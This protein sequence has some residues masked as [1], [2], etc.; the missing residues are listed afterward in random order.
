MAEAPHIMIV[1][2]R[3]Y[4]EIT[5]ELLKGATAVLTEAG[6]TFRRQ[7]V[8]GVFE[9]PA[10]IRMAVKSMEF[11]ID[12]RRIDAF[13]ALGCVIRGETTHYDIVANESAR[14][15]QDLVC[16]FTLALGYGVLTVENE[17]QAW[18]RASVGKKNKGGE[19]ARACLAMLDIKRRL[20]LYPREP[21][22]RA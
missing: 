4:P 13:I 15:L 8:P 6:A 2:A 10:A 3:Y 20:S 21:L 7:E 14:A 18:A 11:S 9:I 1:E 12:R 16:L 5:D 17:E 22:P 19:A